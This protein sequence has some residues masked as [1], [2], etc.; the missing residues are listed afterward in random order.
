MYEVRSAMPIP[1]QNILAFI[2]GEMDAFDAT[3]KSAGL[4]TATTYPEK[5]TGRV[6]RRKTVPAK[7]TYKR[8]R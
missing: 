7:R 4:M 3:T 5:K 6:Y 2:A 1:V 8:A